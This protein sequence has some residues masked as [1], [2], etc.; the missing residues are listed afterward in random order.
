MTTLHRLFNSIKSDNIKI[1]ALAA[2]TID[3]IATAFSEI[4]PHDMVHIMR[5][6]GRT[7]APLFMYCLIIGM[8][9]TKNRRKYFIR[10]YSANLIIAFVWAPFTAMWSAPQVIS[11][12]L[13]VFLYSVIAESIIHSIK[14]KKALS[15]IKNSLVIVLITIIPILLDR[16][17]FE[18]IS[19]TAFNIGG[20]ETS[21]ALRTIF[22]ALIPNIWNIDYTLFFVA[23]GVMWYFCKNKYIISGIL[24][25]FS[26]ISYLGTYKLGVDSFISFFSV[27]QFFMIL[28]APIIM[29]H[30]EQDRHDKS[31]F[32][33][34]FFYFYYPAH[35]MFLKVV[36]SYIT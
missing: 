4:L 6:I 1:I 19:S 12:Y 33:K 10:L 35:Y 7:A 20:I 34:Y 3:H 23:M 13:Y 9:Y 5:I 27:D 36:S 32:S 2:M 25:I 26:V 14:D 30:N 24:V 16:T 17:L 21:T 11:T 18:Y 28:A 8:R 15:A 31:A 29:L 22:R